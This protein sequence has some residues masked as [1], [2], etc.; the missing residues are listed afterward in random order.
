MFRFRVS[1]TYRL[2]VSV[3]VSLS[4]SH[5]VVFEGAGVVLR[6]RARRLVEVLHVGVGEV[7]NP[8]RSTRVAQQRSIPDEAEA[9][10]D[11]GQEVGYRRPGMKHWYPRS[12]ENK[13]AA[14][15]F[16]NPHDKGGGCHV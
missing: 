8:R 13:Y 6:G 4:L 1:N 15:A 9:T 12:W 2:S 10:T 5:H 14:D 11:G 3:S 7:V 16:S